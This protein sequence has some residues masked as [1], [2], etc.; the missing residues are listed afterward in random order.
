M[1]NPETAVRIRRGGRGDHR[2]RRPNRSG[3]SRWAWW[4]STPPAAEVGA[5]CT[6]VDP[7]CD[8][9][10][11]HI[12]G[13]TADMLAGAPT[14]DHIQ[15]FLADLLSGRVVVGHNVDASIW[16][17]C[18]PSASGAGET[19][20][21][22]GPVTTVDTLL[23]GPAPSRS[24]GP[25]HPGG[26]LHPLRARWADH[27]SALGDARVT[28]ALFRSMRAELGDEPLGLA[29]TLRGL[30]HWAVSRWRPGRRARP[31]AG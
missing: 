16:P 30:G 5:F 31:L 20:L 7:G 19:A 3:S 8:P 12:H 21:V 22:P 10:P 18:G 4:C 29:P 13:I 24:A 1:D 28:A 6:L 25:G 15:P 23:R 27:H 26:V 14:F 2:V 9:G 17:S 11:T